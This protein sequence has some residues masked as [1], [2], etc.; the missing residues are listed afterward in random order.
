MDDQVG[1]DLVAVKAKLAER[2]AARVRI[3][4]RLEG[5]DRDLGWIKRIGWTRHFGIRDLLLIADA[6]V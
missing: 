3:G 2:K 4:D 1:Q 5:L 6:A